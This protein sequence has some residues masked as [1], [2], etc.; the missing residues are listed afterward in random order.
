MSSG[1]SFRVG[2]R[3]HGVRI[4]PW[5]N[6]RGACFWRFRH[7]VSG[8]HVSRKVRAQTMAEAKDAL[9]AIVKGEDDFLEL[10]RDRKELLLK[11]M[12]AL[13]DEADLEEFLTW[14]AGAPSA[15]L[16]TDVVADFIAFK[17]AEKGRKTQHLRAVELD[18]ES[19]GAS[20][21]GLDFRDVTS[22]HLTEWHEARAG[23]LSAKRRNDC[24]ANVISLYK[25]AHK[26]GEITADGLQIPQRLAKAKKER[27]SDIRYASSEE[28]LFLLKEVREEYRLWLILGLFAGLRPEEISPEKNRGRRGLH[29][30]EIDIATKTIYVSREVA[31]KTG[32]ARRVPFCQHFEKWLEWASWSPSDLGPIKR[33]TSNKAR[34]TT[35][36]GALMDKEW[37]RSE[38]WPQDI[39]RH[40][41]ASNRA[42]QIQ[43]LPQL[44]LELGNSVS[45]IKDHY[46]QPLPK[47]A[48]DIF[49]ALTPVD[50]ETGKVIAPKFRA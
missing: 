46:N 13:P 5:K 49:F 14:R 30:E 28:V 36:L 47:E 2:S 24:R 10:T 11:V 21:S 23:G 45:V 19:L 34:E 25:Y 1:K 29:R 31:G 48:G 18:L 27:P 42:A 37:N 16:F 6:S 4:S 12:K 33:W 3:S 22:I 7:P 40:T 41:Y 20:L 8:R 35:R 32:S 39:L 38:G 15:R 44:A 17:V 9:E 26:M 43:N 50:L